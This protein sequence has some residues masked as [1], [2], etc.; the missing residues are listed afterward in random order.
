MGVNDDAGNLNA[1]VASPFIAS[2]LAPTGQAFG[3]PMP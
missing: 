1:R 3:E 2:K